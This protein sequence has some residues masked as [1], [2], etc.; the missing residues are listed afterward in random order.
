M[1]GTKSF[2][3]SL[4]KIYQSNFAN[5]ALELFKYQT[6]FNKVCKSYLELLNVNPAGVKNASHMLM[7]QIAAIFQNRIQKKYSIKYMC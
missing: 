4:R 3:G 5:H 7:L 6:V 1:A 2:Q